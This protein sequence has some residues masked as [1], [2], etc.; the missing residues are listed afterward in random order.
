MTDQNS[1]RPAGSHDASPGEAASREAAA[2]R[3]SR[4]I[5]PLVWIVLALLLVWLVVAVM[6]RGGSNRTPSGGSVPSAAEGPSYMPAS[7]AHGSAPATPA[8]SINGPNR[9]A[10]DNAPNPR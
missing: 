5:P 8:G 2:D 7:P 9:P 6:Q 4:R 10:T 1:T 3:P